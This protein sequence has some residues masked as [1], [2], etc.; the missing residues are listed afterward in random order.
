MLRSMPYAVPARLLAAGALALSAVS[1]VPTGARAQA[2][3]RPVVV[4]FTFSNNSVGAG[5]A[6]F[7]GM[8]SGV[9]DLLITDLAS[10]S[11]IR[12][13]DRSRINEVLQEQNM[14]KNGQIDPTTAVRLGKILG[15]QYAITGGF[16][17]L[18][19]GQAVLT[20]RTIDIETTAIDPKTQKITGKTD[21]VLAMLS[22]LSSKISSDMSLAPKPGRRVG[23]AGDAG[24]SSSG[25]ATQS[26]S[27]STK[28]SASTE[29]TETFAKAVSPDVV[30]KTMSSKPDVATLKA[31]SAAL[32]EMDRK[33]NAKA[34]ELLKQ[35][36]NKYP[37]FEPAVRNLSKLGVTV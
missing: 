3:N 11:K 34:I 30:K 33:N 2:D 5:K 8:A 31:Y 23:D 15:A 12:L 36:H 24:K 4:V 9:Q 6:D 1:A 37:D 19:N 14:V 13:V 20:G 21:D 7:D 29:K 22:Q 28:S 27:S 18:G 17:S 35:V 32:D 16:M 26:G 25:S 10:N